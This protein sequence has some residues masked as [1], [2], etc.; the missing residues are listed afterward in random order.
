MNTFVDELINHGMQVGNAVPVLLA[1]A[2]AEQIRE[3]LDEYSER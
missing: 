2:W 3:E 1:K